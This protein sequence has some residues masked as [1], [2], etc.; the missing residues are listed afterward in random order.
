MEMALKKLNR[1][2]AE[3]ATKQPSMLDRTDDH[4]PARIWVAHEFR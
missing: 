2:G 4:S 3:P 1:S